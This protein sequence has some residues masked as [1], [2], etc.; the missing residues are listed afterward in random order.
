MKTIHFIL[1]WLAL[2]FNDVSAQEAEENC[3]F[4]TYINK[5][6]GSFSIAPIDSILMNEGGFGNRAYYTLTPMGWSEDGSLF[7]ME[8]NSYL[9]GGYVYKFKKI[10]FSANPEMELF[11]FEQDIEKSPCETVSELEQLTDKVLVRHHVIVDSNKIGYVSQFGNDFFRYRGFNCTITHGKKHDTIELY[12]YGASKHLVK[13]YISKNLPPTWP[14]EHSCQSFIDI[15][16]YFVNPFNPMQIIIHVF[17]REGCGFENA[18]SFNN[19]FIP[20]DLNEYP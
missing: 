19:M 5:K 18:E 10:Q 17:E 13:K 8:D 16:G 6:F 11:D 4:Y 9:I 20:V 3:E 1:L 15:A 12:K 2:P 7:L 14:G